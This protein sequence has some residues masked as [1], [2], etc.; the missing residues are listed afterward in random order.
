[1]EISTQS[2]E[3]F[4]SLADEPAIVHKSQDKTQQ[5]P[6]KNSKLVEEQFPIVDNNLD[7]LTT[8][9]ERQLSQQINSN[10]DTAAS[11]I[12]HFRQVLKVIELPY[13]HSKLML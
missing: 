7:R 9:M 12:L 6:E 1:M 10:F 3:K 8:C 11:L 2:D 13:I 4:F 5:K